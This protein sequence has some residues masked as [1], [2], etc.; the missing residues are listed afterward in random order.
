M[1]LHTPRFS[2]I[3]ALAENR[4]IGA[5]DR[6]PWHIKEDLMRFKEK[7]TGHAVIMGRSTFESLLGYY[8]RSGRPL[9]KRPHIVV[10]RDT[11][12]HPS[13]PDTYVVSSLEDAFTKGRELEGEE[14]FV[15]GGAQIFAQTIDKVD[16]L[17]LTIVK[18][19]YEGDKFFP[20]YDAFTKVI[21]DTSYDNGNNEFRFVTLERA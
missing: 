7:T 15:S 19:T 18:G 10:T 13:L 2:I 14:I 20:A 12:Y 5:G 16:R 21:E 3:C 8:Q 1:T 4:L 11:A 6:I 9:P 17:Y